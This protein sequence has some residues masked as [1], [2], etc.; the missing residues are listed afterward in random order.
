VTK[1]IVM[2]TDREAACWLMAALLVVVLTFSAAGCGLPPQTAGTDEPAFFAAAPAARWTVRDEADA[3][4]DRVAAAQRDRARSLGFDDA[5][6][7]EPAATLPLFTLEQAAQFDAVNGSPAGWPTPATDAGGEA[8][9]RDADDPRDDDA[10]A[11]A[12]TGG[13]LVGPLAAGGTLTDAA[14]RGV[15]SAAGAIGEARPGRVALALAGAA[16]FAFALQTL[17]L[18]RALGRVPAE[19]RLRLGPAPAPFPR[20]PAG[21][22]ARPLPFAGV[23]AFA[24]PGLARAA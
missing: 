20:P 23:V 24:E 8:P 7:G 5:A 10:A 6:L 3:L 2:T 15:R 13:G 9:A 4:P 19:P 18:V 14:M 17:A 11:G 21:G 1:D 12:L 22:A 16:V